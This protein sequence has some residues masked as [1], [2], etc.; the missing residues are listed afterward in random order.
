MWLRCL[1]G[2]LSLEDFGIKLWECVYGN[3]TRKANILLHLIHWAS[4]EITWDI[5]ITD[6]I[7]TKSCINNFAVVTYHETKLLEKLSHISN[8]NENF[9][10]EKFNIPLF[11]VYL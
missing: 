7:A 8:F 5:L 10:L 1:P 11:S 6:W 4:V 2:I 3:Y 9:F